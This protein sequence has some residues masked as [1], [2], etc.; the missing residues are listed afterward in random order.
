MRLRKRRPTRINETF[1]VSENCKFVGFMKMNR[2]QI[3][4]YPFI[5]ILK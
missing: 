1:G 2:R 5:L 4:L 3:R